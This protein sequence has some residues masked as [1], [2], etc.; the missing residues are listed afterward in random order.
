MIKNYSVHFTKIA[1]NDLDNIY[2]YISAELFAEAA[3]TE[4][5]NRME[6]NIMN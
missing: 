6:N 4:M 3:A 2:S 5:L 1:W